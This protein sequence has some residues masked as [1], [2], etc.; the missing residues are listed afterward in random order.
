MN[1]FKNSV[2]CD[3]NEWEVK[4]L[5]T[6]FSS[7]RNICPIFQVFWPITDFFKMPLSFP[8]HFL[9]LIHY[10]K[11]F[12]VFSKN[13]KLHLSS[14]CYHFCLIFNLLIGQNG[15]STTNIIPLQNKKQK[16]HS[17]FIWEKYL[18]FADC[19]WNILG[20]FSSFFGIE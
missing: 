10:L 19:L 4:C 12:M 13:R 9:F 14:P 20:Y 17:L 3:E 1:E 5:N 11:Y 8:I 18:F 2:E 6:F 16:H 7:L 15:W